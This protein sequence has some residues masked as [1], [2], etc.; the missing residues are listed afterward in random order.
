MKEKVKISICLMVFLILTVMGPSKGFSNEKAPRPE[1]EQ[2]YKRFLAEKNCNAASV[3]L[4]EVEKRGRRAPYLPD[5]WE[6]MIECRKAKGLVY[7]GYVSNILRYYGDVIEVSIGEGDC[8]GAEVILKEVSKRLKR[9]DA[10]T[11]FQV[12]NCYES[13]D[14]QKS[15]AIYREIVEKF[16]EAEVAYDEQGN[17]SIQARQR[18]NWITGDR[19]WVFSDP[20]VLINKVIEALRSRDPK[21]LARLSSQSEFRMG[22]YGGGVFVYLMDSSSKVPE[23]KQVPIK[24]D[25]PMFK[26]SRSELRTEGWAGEWPVAYFIFT[27]DQHGWQWTIWAYANK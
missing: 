8:N 21:K 18:I 6:G 5:W 2:Q 19:S 3:I 10:T 15:L 25:E 23:M 1:E 11:L 14:T 13:V 17:P 7:E 12:G 27:K 20:K 4:D 16:P 9:V 22:P 24:I 26:D